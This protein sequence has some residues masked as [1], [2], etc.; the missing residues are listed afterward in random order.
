MTQLRV[1]GIGSPFGDDKLGWEVVKL[2]QQRAS[3]NP[4]IPLKLDLSYW[5][6][7]GVHLL[8]LMRGATSIFLIDA[9]KTGAALGTIHQ[10]QNE[11]IETIGSTLSTHGLGIAE[12]MK[13]GA[14]LHEL[15]KNVILYGVEIGEVQLQLTFSE[16]IITAI[17]A[18][19]DQIEKDILMWLYPSPTTAIQS[20]DVEIANPAS[21]SK[22]E[23]AADD[24]D[25]EKEADQ[26]ISPG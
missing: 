18:L 3:L 26:Q 8:E 20:L 16:P 19:S 23:V 17:Q 7:P 9:V 1:L 13:M 6:R 21:G 25:Q 14:V 10:F 24:K 5:D 2:L 4:Y 12:A 22:N 11:E 15:P